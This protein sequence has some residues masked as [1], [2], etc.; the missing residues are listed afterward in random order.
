MT[1]A[2]PNVG[3]ILGWRGSSSSSLLVEAA[4]E[5]AAA[6]PE[7]VGTVEDVLEVSRAVEEGGEAELLSAVADGS[8]LNVWPSRVEVGVAEVMLSREGSS[9][10][11]LVASVVSVGKF[12]SAVSCRCC[13]SDPPTPQTPEGSLDPSRLKTII[14]ESRILVYAGDERTLLPQCAFPNGKRTPAH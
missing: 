2:I 6:A 7:E 5:A 12:V 11:A 4:V 8:E 14:G 3:V 1:P 13:M 9:V 10:E